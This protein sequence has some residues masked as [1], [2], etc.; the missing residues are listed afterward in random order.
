[1]EKIKKEVEEFFANKELVLQ[2]GYFQNMISTL[3]NYF[4]SIIFFT[5]FMV[6]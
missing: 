3:S 4:F 5:I 2:S 1:L 6:I